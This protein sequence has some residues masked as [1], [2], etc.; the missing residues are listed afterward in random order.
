MR[1]PGF[2]GEWEVKK[3]GEFIDIISGIPLKSKD[4][5]EDESGIPILRGIN[6]TEGFIRHNKEIDRYYPNPI[7]D[8]FQKFLLEEKDLVLGM[9]GSK[10][11]KNVALIPNSDVGSILIQRVA[12]IRALSNADI[13]FLFQVIFSKKFQQY[14][15]IVNTS[16]GIPH[17]SLQQIINYKIAFPINLL[18]QKKI[19]IFL[20]LIDQRITTQSKIIEKYESL[21]KGIVDSIF[22]K[23]EKNVKLN[24]CL[25]C[26]SSALTESEVV[27]KGMYPV[28]GAAGIF[29]YFSQYHIN[30][31]SILI[32]KDGSNVGK[33]QY[34][35][36]KYSVIGTLNY[37]TAKDSVCLKYIYYYMQSFNFDKYKVGSGI[38]HIYFKDYGN[39]PVYC[40][41]F[42]EQEKIA[43]ALSSIEQK[44]FVEKN[45]LENF[46]K[47]KNYLLQ[48]FFI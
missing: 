19:S 46:F 34:A 14:V 30:G 17:I 40:P 29:A 32:I 16:S 23:K 8:K 21:I 3:L 33:L 42:T 45:I 36:N 39:E 5:S 27:D 24:D 47:Q 4:I 15:D 20:S 1:F 12:R 10:V 28:Y 7:S 38:P 44:I 31:D 11:G 22:K 9:D 25:I 26:H 41:E 18:E 37:L 35:S 43:N 13:D 48:N 2:E 6:I